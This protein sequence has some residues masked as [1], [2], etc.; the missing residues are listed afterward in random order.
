MVVFN[1]ES[2]I[3]LLDAVAASCAVPL[4]WPAAT[5]NGKRYIDGGVR[6]SANADLAT[7]C[8]R[9]VVLAPILASLRRSGRISRQLA[10]LA[11]GAFHRHLTG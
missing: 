8:G 2:G 6:S 7:G 9:V 1:R 4:V 3:S 11:E 10:T 5:I